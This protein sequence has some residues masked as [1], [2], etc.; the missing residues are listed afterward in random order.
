[1]VGGVLDLP[2]AASFDVFVTVVGGLAADGGG[3]GIEEDEG[4]GPE[5]AR[6]GGAGQ[7]DL[8]VSAHVEADGAYLAPLAAR[9]AQHGDD[10]VGAVEL[11][12]AVGVRGGDVRG[13]AGADFLP[14][15]VVQAAPVLVLEALDGLEVFDGLDAAFEVGRGAFRGFGLCVAAI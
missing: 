3:A 12:S 4:E 11:Q 2:V 13:E 1:L 14:K 15:G 10:L 9:F 6:G 5:A 7:L 8:R